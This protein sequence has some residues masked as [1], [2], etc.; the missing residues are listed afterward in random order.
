MVTLKIL[1]T[2]PRNHCQKIPVTTDNHHGNN[3]IAVTIVKNDNTI[4]Q[5]ECIN[6]WGDWLMQQI[7]DSTIKGL[8][9]NRDIPGG[10][11]STT[12]T[13]PSTTHTEDNNT[14]ESTSSSIPLA[15]VG[16]GIAATTL[17]AAI[18]YALKKLRVVTIQLVIKRSPLSRQHLVTYF[19][20]KM[21]NLFMQYLISRKRYM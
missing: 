12:S 9:A 5:F 15:I 10:C 11:R 1:S 21:L 4:Q 20:I 19:H 18:I 16:T 2:E 7:Q 8:F 17:I 6:G 3:N 13:T 14:E